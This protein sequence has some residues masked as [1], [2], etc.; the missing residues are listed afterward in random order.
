MPPCFAIAPI[1]PL[2]IFS[3]PAVHCRSLLPGLILWPHEG[4]EE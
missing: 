2:F 3:L 1:D 4:D